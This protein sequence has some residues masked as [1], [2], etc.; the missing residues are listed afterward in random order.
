MPV[1]D[2]GSSTC[3]RF[4]DPCSKLRITLELLGVDAF[5]AEM[6]VELLSDDPEDPS[7]PSAVALPAAC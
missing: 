2:L 3:T 4:L 6:I 7:D 1:P 5:Q